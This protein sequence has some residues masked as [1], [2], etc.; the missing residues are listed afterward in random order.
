MVYT[1]QMLKRALKG[2]FKHSGYQNYL[3]LPDFVYMKFY[4][5]ALVSLC[6]QLTVRKADTDIQAS[7][8]FSNW[9]HTCTYASRS[10][11]M[12]FNMH[13]STSTCLI[14]QPVHTGYG[15]DPQSEISN[16]TKT[17][18]IYIYLYICVNSNTSLSH[19]K[20]L[21]LNYTTI[22]ETNLNLKLDFPVP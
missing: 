10:Q 1:Q 11:G 14:H 8:L 12:R 22:S 21:P 20:H 2:L 13:T 16:C 19:Y 4:D 3:Y 5:M 17:A 6:S 7:C 15:T 9:I 18:Y